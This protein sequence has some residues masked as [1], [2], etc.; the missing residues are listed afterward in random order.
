MEDL[1]LARLLDKEVDIDTQ[2]SCMVIANALDSRNPAFRVPVVL[3]AVEAMEEEKELRLSIE[4][5]D[6]RSLR[7][8]YRQSMNATYIVGLASKASEQ[9]TNP[10]AK[11]ALRDIEDDF[12]DLRVPGPDGD[13]TVGVPDPLQL[14]PGMHGD[15][16]K[17]GSV[18]TRPVKHPP[19]QDDRT[20]A[21]HAAVVKARSAVAAMAK[22]DKPLSVAV[23]AALVADLERRMGSED[24]AKTAAEAAQHTVQTMMK[25]E[26]KGRFND[27]PTD[28]EYDEYFDTMDTLVS[29]VRALAPWMRPADA[30]RVA[31]QALANAGGGSGHYLAQVVVILAP[32]MQPADTSEV[33]RSA[34]QEM[35]MTGLSNER[36][37]LVDAVAALIA[38]VGPGETSQRVDSVASAVGDAAALQPLFAGL[39]PLAHA[40]SPLPGRLTEQQLV[41]LLKAPICPPSARQVIVAQLGN[42]CGRPF[43][44]LWDFVDWAREHRPDLDLTSPPDR[45]ASP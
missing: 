17:R 30:A 27:G 18:P 4:L 16:A 43:A 25:A 23:L 42:Q 31:L 21:E 22:A 29:A 7:R 26:P 39:V 35:A 32:R 10:V 11:Q 44:N 36:D 9:E 19:L 8:L 13:N 12:G 6:V 3:K 38:N 45:P 40:Y 41:D 20:E 28:L 1:L 15:P 5:D 2:T 14:P 37:A 34:V 33:A 24:A